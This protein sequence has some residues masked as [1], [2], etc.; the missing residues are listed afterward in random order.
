M[1]RRVIVLALLGAS[2]GTLFDIAHVQTG[3]IGYPHPSYLGIAWWVPLLYTGASLAIGLSHPQMDALLG[4]PRV[5]LDRGRLLVGFV[6]LCAIWFA[7]GA[8]HLDTLAVS[9][10][11]APASL[12]L[13]FF[14]DRTWQGLAIAFGT[15]IMGCAIEVVLSGA[16]FFHHEH[17][18][19][20]G[21]AMWLP[22]IYVAASVGLGN[23]GRWLA[24]RDVDPVTTQGAAIVGT[25]RI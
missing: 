4:K 11:L 18:D 19:L 17:P 1:L 20:L 15:A 10:I 14:L 23:V 21:I 3:A 22:W 2:F 24:S 8:I 5:S 13:W 6:G 12:A 9:A 7:S 16:G 25:S